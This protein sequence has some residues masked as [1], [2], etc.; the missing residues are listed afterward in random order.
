MRWKFPALL[1]EFSETGVNAQ[2]GYETPDDLRDHY[3]TVYR[4]VV[5]PYIDAGLRHLQATHMGKTWRANLYAQVF[6]VEQRGLWCA[7]GA[8][9]TA[10]LYESDLLA[11]AEPRLESMWSERL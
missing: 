1:A 3:P 7:S 6:A 5:A 8:D 2:F 4:Q 9:R 11:A 10:R